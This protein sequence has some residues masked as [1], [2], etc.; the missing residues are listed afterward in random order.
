MLRG[1]RAPDDIGRDLVGSAEPTLAVLD[2]VGT[3]VSA[4]QT[5]TGGEVHPGEGWE[6]TIYSK[7]KQ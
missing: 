3:T 4:D 2:D 5:A 1:E 7:A 6:V